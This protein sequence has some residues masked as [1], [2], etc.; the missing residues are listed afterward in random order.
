MDTSGAPDRQS[1]QFLYRT[2]AGQIDARTWWRGALPLA[3]IVIVLTLLLV[4]IF[5]YTE[6]DLTRSPLLS[7]TALGA[8]LY[9]IFYSFLLILI[10]ICY[11][12]LSA[13][14]WRDLKRP[15][16]LAGLVPFCA[17]LAGAAHW[18]A[19][20]SSEIVPQA[21]PLAA[22]ICFVLV[23][24]WNVAELAGLVRLRTPRN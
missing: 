10:G 16:A 13:K 22:D 2:D 1:W 19:A 17:L 23:L 5:P 6:H 18:L 14:R 12:N 7:A 20:R 9:V 24:I 4:F 15:P 21:V 3:A 8:N 11:Y